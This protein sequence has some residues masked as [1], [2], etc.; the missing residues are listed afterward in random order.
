MSRPADPS[1]EFI[2][3]VLIPMRDGV[4]LAGNLYRPAGTGRH[5]CVVNYIPYHKDGRGGRG[6]A[7]AVHRHF[8]ARGYAALV[9]DFRGLGC[10]EGVNSVPFDS[11]EGRDGHDIVEWAAAQPWCDGNV[12]MWGVSYGGITALKAAAERPPHLKAIVPIHACADIRAGFLTLGGCPNGFWANGDWGPR[13]VGYN[14]T[15]PL[16]DDPDGRLARI[17]AE[18]LERAEPWALEWY[19]HGDDAGRWAGRAVPVER[20]TAATYAVCGWHDFYVDG[21]AAYFNRIPAPRKLLLGPWKHVFP[22]LDPVEPINFLEVMVRWWDRWLRGADNGADAGPPVALFCQGPDGGTWRHEEA[23]PPSRNHGHA[24]YLLPRG[25]L[26]MGEIW[27]LTDV[28]R[29]AAD[30]TVGLDSLGRDPWTTAVAD[31]GNHNADEARS[32]HFTTR[33]LGQAWELTGPARLLLTVTTSA[34]GLT[35]TAKLSDVSP[36]DQSRLVTMG[37]RRDAEAWSEERHQVEVPLRATSYLFRQGHRI[38]L[39]LALADFPR[40]WPRPGPAYIVVHQSADSPSTLLLPRTPEPD[41]V[42]P[43]PQ[44]PPRGEPPHSEA[45]LE[46]SQRWTVSRELVR[47]AA[48]LGCRTDSR[49]QLAAAGT[50]SLRHEYTATVAEQDAATIRSSS[51][52]HV[53]RPGGVVRVRTTNVFTADAVTI[54]AEIEQAGR[55]IFRKTWEHRP[56]GAAGG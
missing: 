44:F 24:L 37:W 18:R 10:S 35:F 32:L 16:A 33:P 1:V 38:R 41:P 54:E 21:T 28:A 19:R 6:Y 36:E 30:P 2:P 7:E 55:V 3:N 5:P 15:P 13:M 12:G 25:R 11:Q 14:L 17:W 29:Y 20:V 50:V 49:Y 51:D 22:D 48:A 53:D 31:P 39:S 46:S 4:R 45:E 47:G 42:L 27:E 8:A 23:W 43:P 56:R 52:I 26:D 9:V 34:P 40:L